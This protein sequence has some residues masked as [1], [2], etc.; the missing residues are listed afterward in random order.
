MRAVPLNDR[1]HLGFETTGNEDIERAG[2]AV[3]PVLEIVYD[4]RRH[5]EKGA[6]GRV[7]VLVADDEGE[8]AFDYVEQF[9]VVLMRVG[10]RPRSP[11]F[12]H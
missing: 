8:S 11:G 2:P 6:G 1:R 12:T 5:A 4:T 7:D 9:L 10:T 3:G